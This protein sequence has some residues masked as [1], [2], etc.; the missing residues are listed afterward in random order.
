MA[1]VGQRKP[2]QLIWEIVH[3]PIVE[4]LSRQSW[5]GCLMIKVKSFQPSTVSIDCMLSKA[6]RGFLSG[7][8]SASTV[9]SLHLHVWSHYLVQATGGKWPPS[10]T[11]HL[12]FPYC[13]IDPRK[14]ISVVV[15]PASVLGLW[16]IWPK[17]TPV[18][19]D[20]ICLLVRVQ[21]FSWHSEAPE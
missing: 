5:M 10:S 14:S 13:S 7:S 11:S 21:S 16:L 8:S 19:R 2:T 15:L 9:L 6:S 12:I 17:T 3:S 4:N 1:V 18:L 20:G